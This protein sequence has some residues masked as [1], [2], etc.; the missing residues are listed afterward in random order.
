[1]NRL[2]ILRDRAFGVVIDQ[3]PGHLISEIVTGGAVDW[4]ILR[5]LFL[6]GQ[7]FLDD[8]INRAPILW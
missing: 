6:A 5:Q 7:D 4:P 1:M 3:H 2:K 8:Q